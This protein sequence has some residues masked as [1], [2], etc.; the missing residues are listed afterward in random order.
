MISPYDAARTIGNTRPPEYELGLIFKKSPE[1]LPANLLSDVGSPAIFE[2][3]RTA[4]GKLDAARK[5]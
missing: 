5:A 4:R 2:M 1:P 3:G